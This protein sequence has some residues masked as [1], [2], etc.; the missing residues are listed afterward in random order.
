MMQEETTK[1]TA[2]VKNRVPPVA[3]LT[4]FVWISQYT[5]EE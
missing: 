5:L 4:D 2:I 3:L 1:E